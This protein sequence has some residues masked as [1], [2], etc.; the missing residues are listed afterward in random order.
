MSDGVLGGQNW[1]KSM[2]VQGSQNVQLVNFLSVS[3][4]YVDAL[5]IS[6]KKKAENFF[7]QIF[8]LML[9]INLAR[10]SIKQI[11]WKRDFKRNSCKRTWRAGTCYWKK[12]LLGSKLFEGSWCGERF[13]FY[14][15]S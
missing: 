15:I 2:H 11:S 7:L 5:G 3:N 6:T 14:F 13:S 10:R 4:D 9:Q 8:Q 1:T 12:C